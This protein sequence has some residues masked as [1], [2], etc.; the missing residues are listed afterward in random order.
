M[1]L[2]FILPIYMYRIYM[3]FAGYGFDSLKIC[4]LPAYEIPLLRWGDVRAVLSLQYLHWQ[5]SALILNQGLGHEIIAHVFYI[6]LKNITCFRVVSG[7]E[8]IVV[9]VANLQ[10]IRHTIRNLCSTMTSSMVITDPLW[11]EFIGERRILSQTTS[12]A[13]FWYFLSYWLEQA[14]EQA[15]EW[16]SCDSIVMSYQV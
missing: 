7:S 14:V 12:N 2:C 15:I 16:L 8:M 5:D 4:F 11:R 10:H 13:Q 1:Y 9:T 3:N 6:I